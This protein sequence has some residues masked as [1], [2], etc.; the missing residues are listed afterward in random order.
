MIFTW[1]FF[2]GLVIQAI[3][4]PFG[5]LTAVEQKYEGDYRYLHNEILVHSEEIAFY[6]GQ[7][8]E[9]KNIVRGYER[10]RLHA[11]D[12]LA[13][14]FIMGIFDSMLVK[15]GAVTVGYAIVGLPVFGPGS[16]EYVKNMGNDTSALMGDY[17]RNSSMLV[18]L[19]KAV[20]RLVV[21]YK[22][23]Q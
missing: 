13:K 11:Q 21:S 6:K 4:P 10:L 5:R 3:S 19:S 2:S 22:E 17:I 14:K 18:N 9:K 8:W 16:E 1:Y 23:V 7:E 12:V 20:G 15:Y